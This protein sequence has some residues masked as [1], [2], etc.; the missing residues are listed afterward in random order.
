VIPD[1]IAS[2]KRAIELDPND[3]EGYT[4]LGTIDTV[5]LW[6]WDAAE[7][8]L[9][10]GIELSSNSALAEI[11]Y[12]N[13]LI[14]RART[15]EAIAHMRKAVELD[16]LSFFANRQLG[17]ALYLGRH[18]DEALAALVRASEIAPDGVSAVQGWVSYIYE[19]EGKYDQSAAAELK[20]IERYAS[21]QQIYLMRSG[22]EKSGWKGY[23][24]AHL[25][26]S[27]SRA[28]QPCISYDIAEDY[29]A[30]GRVDE[31]FDWFDRALDEHC[32][33][34]MILNA[35][36][37]HDGVRSDPRFHVLLRRMNLVQ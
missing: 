17:S 22:Y 33:F 13:Y 27:L 5:F 1:A 16:P 37:R 23:R 36:P 18:Y 34:M 24:E 2:A 29:R 19:V 20:G 31:A 8:N 10:R 26:Y 3:G 14:V 7:R 30:I 35:D 12:A 11:R 6:D 15:E 25:Q 4:A 28:G 32:I 9:R 21:P